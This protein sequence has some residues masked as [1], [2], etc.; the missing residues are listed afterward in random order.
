LKQELNQIY[1]ANFWPGPLAPLGKTVTDI[2]KDIEDL[3]NK[4]ERCEVG[5]NHKRSNSFYKGIINP[6]FYL[7]KNTYFWIVVD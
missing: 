2:E 7:W 5:I 1:N 3:E 6:P 4:P